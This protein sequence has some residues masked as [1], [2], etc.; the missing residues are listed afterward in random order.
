MRIGPDKTFTSAKRG[1]SQ[2][3]GHME[4]H[5]A[6]LDEHLLVIS[7]TDI[8]SMQRQGDSG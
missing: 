1:S 6:A 2:F 5:A 8:A 7:A 3:T 4:S